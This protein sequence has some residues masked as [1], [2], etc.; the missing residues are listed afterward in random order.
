MVAEHV[1]SDAYV[2]LLLFF[3][4]SGGDLEELLEFIFAHQNHSRREFYLF[5]ICGISNN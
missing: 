4:M 3:D 5:V 2:R 1:A